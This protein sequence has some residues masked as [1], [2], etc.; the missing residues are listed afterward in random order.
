MHITDQDIRESL[1]DRLAARFSKKSIPLS[2]VKRGYEM[3]LRRVEA[4]E[5]I[6]QGVY[7]PKTAIILKN[8]VVAR[9]KHV[10]EAVQGAYPLKLAYRDLAT[11]TVSLDYLASIHP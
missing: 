10:E 8:D 6:L 11:A 2:T 5:Q 9:L 1:T 4:V 3:L 7:D